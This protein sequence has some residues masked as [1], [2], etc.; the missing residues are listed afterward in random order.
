MGRRPIARS[1]RHLGS[2]PSES[3]AWA[4]PC[5]Q[6]ARRSFSSPGGSLSGSSV[7]LHLLSHVLA[8]QERRWIRTYFYN[9]A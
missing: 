1:V 4:P 9:V 7:T 6:L 2:Q 8:K 5:A 3:S